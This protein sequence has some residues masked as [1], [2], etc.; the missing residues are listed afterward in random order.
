MK[1]N[2]THEELMAAAKPLV[3]YLKKQQQGIHMKVIVETDYVEVVQGVY[4]INVLEQRK[5]PENNDK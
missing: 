1:G 5:E 4:G 3:E 2:D